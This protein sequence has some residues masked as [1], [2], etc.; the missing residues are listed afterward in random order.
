MRSCCSRSRRCSACTGW[1]H[2]F[3]LINS[4]PVRLSLSL[5]RTSRYFTTLNA[6]CISLRLAA[7][8]ALCSATIFITG[9]PSHFLTSTTIK[10][11]STLAR[12]HLIRFSR[13][14]CA[15]TCS[16]SGKL[17][18]AE[19]QS[20]MASLIRISVKRVQ[21]LE[22]YQLSPT[23][24]SS[25]AQRRRTRARTLCE[26]FR[27]KPATICL[28]ILCQWWVCSCWFLSGRCSSS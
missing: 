27:Q 11:P 6:S 13:L 4:R 18:T 9:F 25:K 19:P 24:T 3:A 26:C 21:S 23:W 7:C 20:S 15:S 14:K 28:W 22:K 12:T 16:L 8:N 10:L 1:T 2:S 17:C 5:V